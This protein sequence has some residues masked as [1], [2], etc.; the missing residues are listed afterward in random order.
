MLS[1]QDRSTLCCGGVV[2]VPVSDSLVGE[3]VALLMNEAVAD[4]AP[5]ACG[6]NVTVN[7]LLPPAEMVKGNESP[8]RANSEV[9]TLAEDTV[10]LAP[11][12]FSVPVRLA[13][14]P[15]VTLPKFSVAGVTDNCPAAVPVPDRGTDKFGFDPL[16]TTAMLPLTAPAEVGAKV[17]LK[18]KLCPGVK[19]SGGLIP[20]TLKPLPVTVT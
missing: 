3:F 9:L 1:L 20:L 11:V 8:L 7:D 15:T 10:T 2:P 17:A 5:L 12:A 19:V 14:D 13:L 4:A 16:D 6:V 18:V